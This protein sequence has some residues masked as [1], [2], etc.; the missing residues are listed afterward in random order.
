MK[1]QNYFLGMA[2]LMGGAAM[3]LGACGTNGGASDASGEAAAVQEGD[4]LQVVTTFYPMYDFTKNVAQDKADVSLLIPAGTEI[5]SFEPSTKMIAVIQEADVFVYNSDEM[6]TWVPAVLDAIDTSDMVIIN[7]SEGIELLDFDAEEHHE[8]ET[9]EEHEG[10]E[11]TFDPHVWLDPVLAQTEV[12]NIQ[13][14][15]AEADAEN[16]AFYEEN[17]EAYKEK[18]AALD[19]AFQAAFEGATNRTFVTQH[20]AFAYLANRYDLEQVSV[21]GLTP[22]AE[23]SAA[24]L[25]ELSDFVKEHGTE[26]IYF[27]DNASSTTAETL[28]DE[29]GLQLEVLSPLEGI[30]QEDQDAGVD[31]IQVMQSNLEALK[32]AI[33]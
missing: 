22:D 26:Y 16:A 1:K 18:L 14:G 9:E 32:K 10:H 13:A 33:K 11:H 4:K 29:A 21:S 6:E 17:A 3:L 12:D 8:G 28:A 2:A 24:V 27:E 31:Y 7:A 5:H 23:P 15:L 30:A 25:A 19:E 20:G